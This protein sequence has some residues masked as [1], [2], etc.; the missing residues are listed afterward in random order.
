MAAPARASELT[1]PGT[2]A[3]GGAFSSTFSGGTLSGDDIGV[4]TD[5]VDEWLVAG[6]LDLGGFLSE[7][8]YLGGAI[9][10][11]YQNLSLDGDTASTTT[12][13]LQVEPRYYIALSQ[14]RETFLQLRAFLGFASAH[15]AS[16]DGGSEESSTLQGVLF[17]AGAFLTFALGEAQGGFVDLGVKVQKL[18]LSG[19]EDDFGIDVT[20][21]QTVIAFTLGLGAF[22]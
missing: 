10:V 3:I 2:L 14:S 6:E 18:I 5:L 16:N 20:S 11:S 15:D 9:G 13:F 1:Q 8:F 21:D 17:G 12:G 22:L 7:G 19:D 4:E